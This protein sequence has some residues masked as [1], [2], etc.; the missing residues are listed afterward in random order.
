M[1]ENVMFRNLSKNTQ[2]HKIANAINAQRDA[3]LGC[4][5]QDAAV[6]IAATKKLGI[7]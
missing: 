2:V 1:L 5:G 7:G 4:L 3:L 6:M